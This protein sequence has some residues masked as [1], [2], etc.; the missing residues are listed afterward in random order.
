MH[1]YRLINKNQLLIKKSEKKTASRR[2]ALGNHVTPKIFSVVGIAGRCTLQ[3]QF[4]SYFLLRFFIDCPFNTS[5]C[6]LAPYCPLPRR[7]SL[8]FV[9]P[10]STLPL[11]CLTPAALPKSYHHVFRRRSSA[12]HAGAH[13]GRLYR[14]RPQR[15]HEEDSHCHS[16][17]RRS[18]FALKGQTDN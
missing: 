12:H 15:N 6:H 1:K 16:Q 13:I 18:F 9:F 8:L 5:I 14:C 11:S 7:T 4:S 10:P 3:I 17:E 2:R